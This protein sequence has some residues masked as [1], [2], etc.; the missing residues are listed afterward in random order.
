[1]KAAKQLRGET[2]I[3]I[4]DKP[5]QDKRL[6][7]L[8]KAEQKG[9]L[10]LGDLNHEEKIQ[11]KQWFEANFNAMPLS[12]TVEYIEQF[13]GF[14]LMDDNNA[15]RFIR[16]LGKEEKKELGIFLAKN[17]ESG[18][19]IRSF[20]ECFPHL[21]YD[22]KN[23]Y[24]QTL[25]QREPEQLVMI[26]PFQDLRQMKKLVTKETVYTKTTNILEQNTVHFHQT[27]QMIEHTIRYALD[28]PAHFQIPN[29]IE[30]TR[31]VRAKWR[32]NPDLYPHLL[33]GLAEMTEI[34]MRFSGKKEDDKA[35][36]YNTQSAQRQALR[37]SIASLND[38][39]SRDERQIERE[40]D[41]VEK[42]LQELPALSSEKIFDDNYR[43]T[44]RSNLFDTGAFRMHLLYPY[45]PRLVEA[46]IIDPE[47]ARS[48]VNPLEFKPIS[49][50]HRLVE[51]YFS[52]MGGKKFLTARE[53]EKLNKI[54]HRL[55][56]KYRPDLE[57]NPEQLSIYSIVQHNR[58]IK[59][60]LRYQE[61]TD[62][63]KKRGIEH[64]FTNFKENKKYLPADLDFTL[65]IGSLINLS[66]EPLLG[67][68]RAG[69]S[70]KEV[71]DIIDAEMELGGELLFDTRNLAAIEELLA[72]ASSQ[73][74]AKYLHRM[75]EL[76]VDQ[77]SSQL[78]RY[79]TTW[80]PAYWLISNIENFLQRLSKKNQDKLIENITKFIPELWFR[81]LKYA[82]D[83]GI[84]DIRQLLENS[85]SYS[86]YLV[87]NYQ[88]ILSDVGR[89]TKDPKERRSMLGLLKRKVREIFLKNPKLLLLKFDQ[90]VCGEIFTDQEI[91]Q[92]IENIIDNKMDEDYLLL[93]IQPGLIKRHEE[94]IKS[95]L[96]DDEQFVKIFSP[97]H[98]GS[99]LFK[100]REI[101]GHDNFIN[102]I[103][104]NIEHLDDHFLIKEYFSEPGNMLKLVKSSEQFDKLIEATI[105][106]NPSALGLFSYSFAALE[107]MDAE[108]LR[109]WRESIRRLKD[110]IIR[111]KYALVENRKLIAQLEEQLE[112]QYKQK[113]KKY[114]SDLDNEIMVAAGKKMIDKIVR[115]CGQE[116]FFVFESKVY[117][118][119]DPK[120]FAFV[121]AELEQYARKNPDILTSQTL[122]NR[123]K[124]KELDALADQNLRELVFTKKIRGR[125]V[126]KIKLG[127]HMKEKAAAINP[128]HG[129]EDN[130]E[131]PDDYYLLLMEK[132]KN[133]AF[134]PLFQ[135]RLEKIA[136]REIKSNG[137]TTNTEVNKTNEEFDEIITLLALLRQSRPAMEN[138]QAIIALPHEQRNNMIRMLEFL[139]FYGLDHT[140]VF[141]LEKEGYKAVDRDLTETV[142]R[143][144]KK[145]LDIEDHRMLTIENLNMEEIKALIVY[146][147]KT[148]HKQTASKKAFAEMIISVLEGK[149]LSWRQFNRSAEPDDDREKRKCLEELQQRQLMP[150]KLSLKQ[151]NIWNDT[152][153]LSVEEV[154]RY[155]INDIQSAIKDV[156]EQAVANQHIEKSELEGTEK[157]YLS[158]LE[159]NFAPIKF[160]SARIKELKQK[161]AREKQVS[162]QKGIKKKQYLSEKE[163]KELKDLK[164]NIVN[165]RKNNRQKL[166]H[167]NA[168]LYLEKLKNISVRELE[169]DSLI[170]K[171]QKR[172]SLKKVFDL[173]TEV[174]KENYPEFAYDVSRIE[175]NIRQVSKQ[176]FA[177]KT[178]AKSQL[179][180]NDKID[181]QTYLLIGKY[182]VDSCQHYD[183]NLN[184]NL[185]LLSY[186]T[187]PNVKII[188]MYDDRGKLIARSVL[189]LM[190]NHQ[191]EP[192]LFMEYVYSNNTHFKIKEVMLQLAKNKGAKMGIKVYVD[193]N[194]SKNV[195]P[196]HEVLINKNTRGGYVYTDA[197]EGLK[198][199][200]VFSINEPY[201]A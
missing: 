13:I 169:Q 94:N 65:F 178:I 125:L 104:H 141:N 111:E 17:I 96:N 146:Y 3:P 62:K 114:L 41:N 82:R 159:K 24:V 105:D 50:E 120:I 143:F 135:K 80:Y 199:N 43:K 87:D 44:V 145:Q 126:D 67:L 54:Y 66:Y 122:N 95:L 180:M 58:P 133:Y 90:S 27:K 15:L 73:G 36:E 81:N 32:E 185:G 77:I 102:K 176:I 76:A 194:L 39:R 161:I 31:M 197:G 78:Q 8:E 156:L 97:N 42:I 2:K 163:N 177:G 109:A 61:I 168:M 57:K 162:K 30:Y 184:T 164:K 6:P 183:S 35:G 136:R 190:P 130:V 74:D 175:K 124:P 157:E 155:E 154:L 16:H 167:I 25:T 144:I 18:K 75:E 186:L 55:K 127:N 72:F 191:G 20:Y 151:F 165:Y 128:F 121:E 134:F 172:I 112:K 170:I 21:D 7:V 4:P 132:V 10:D 158:Q 138:K 86:F 49:N 63:A 59:D 33:K 195:S 40:L 98:Y 70:K 11:V 192:K 147:R 200:G 60:V 149:Y 28:H 193:Q 137:K 53:T 123:I 113:P 34:L 119:Q 38:T 160:W 201:I 108:N 116:K 198:K 23:Q 5:V 106:K 101:M 139:S 84:T 51:P 179:H 196:S 9:G 79:G 69:F 115:K 93:L 188:Q 26:M 71:N 56:K 1:M 103:I 88:E 181:F 107:K 29:L 100:I 64:F 182:P 89:L 117:R 189:R 48:L 45:I 129:L 12:E 47:E 187:D 14:G 92:I 150:E 22:Q 131:L 37:D 110:T 91:D 174:F 140:I 166:D 153:E 19:Y 171:G 52:N 99:N 142:D 152:E 83:N 68:N 173:L 46:G 148:I 85:D 118:L